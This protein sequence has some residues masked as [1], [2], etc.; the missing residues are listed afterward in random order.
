M[1]VGW[2]KTP[3]GAWQSRDVDI[4]DVRRVPSTRSGYCSTQ[5]KFGHDMLPNSA[6]PAAYR[7][8]DR[9]ST[10]GGLAQIMR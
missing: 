1:P 5:D 8:I 9:Y 10:P 6:A 4:I 7:D 3:W 2:P